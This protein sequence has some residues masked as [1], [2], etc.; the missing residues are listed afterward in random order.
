MSNVTVTLPE[1]DTEA[2]FLIADKR[3]LSQILQELPAYYSICSGD[4]RNPDNQEAAIYACH[5]PDE[6]ALIVQGP[7][8]EDV[9]YRYWVKRE[10][11]CGRYTAVVSKAVLKPNPAMINNYLATLKEYADDPTA[12]VFFSEDRLSAYLTGFAAYTVGAALA[13]EFP[14]LFVASPYKLEFP[15]IS[16]EVI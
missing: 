8:V 14:R 10:I 9:L 12:L 16:Q 11:F 6:E 15:Q 13:K 5:N 4:F 2:L 1:L 3:P 7:S